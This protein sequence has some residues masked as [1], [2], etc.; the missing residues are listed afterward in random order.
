MFELAFG[1][2]GLALV[3]FRR[4]LAEF[5]LEWRKLFPPQLGRDATRTGEVFL[6]LVG[7]FFI[8]CSVGALLFA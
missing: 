3:A 8:A 6:A 2:I 7:L 1:L 4:P 5:I